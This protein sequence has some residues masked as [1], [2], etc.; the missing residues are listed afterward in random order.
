MYFNL[1]F[2]IYVYFI[3]IPQF[4]LPPLLLVPLPSPLLYSTIQSFCF[5]LEKG[6]YPVDINKI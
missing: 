3:S 4:S 2:K 5:Y 1:Y 6:R